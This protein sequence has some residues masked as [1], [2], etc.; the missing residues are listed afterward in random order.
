MNIVLVDVLHDGEYSVQRG[1]FYG[2]V[3]HCVVDVRRRH[4]KAFA[5]PSGW[6]ESGVLKKELTVEQREVIGNRQEL[7]VIW[8]GRFQTSVAYMVRAA[9][10][11]G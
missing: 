5:S 1:A 8:G 4:P 11:I 9:A 7:C 6:V 10:P 2:D 3:A